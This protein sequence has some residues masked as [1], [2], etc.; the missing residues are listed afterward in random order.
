MFISAA[1]VCP[2]SAMDSF[3]WSASRTG[4]EAGHLPAQ[5]HVCVSLSSVLWRFRKRS[6]CVTQA[7]TP[8]P[9]R[10]SPI[11]FPKEIQLLLL[12]P[13]LWKPEN[14]FLKPIKIRM[15]RHKRPTDETRWVFLF[16]V[17]VNHKCFAAALIVEPHNSWWSNVHKSGHVRLCVSS[18]ETDRRSK[19]KSRNPQHVFKFLFSEEKLGELGKISTTWMW[20]MS[21]S[22]LI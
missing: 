10:S 13:S 21:K 12:C 4:G 17:H 20:R 19:Q 9:W 8:S 7:A 5:T 11:R 18:N 15:S 3:I 6:V 16:D 14:S 22:V 1:R 2:L